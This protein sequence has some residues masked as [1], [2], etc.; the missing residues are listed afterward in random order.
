MSQASTVASEAR[1]MRATSAF[2][3]AKLSMREMRLL[4]RRRGSGLC[5]RLRG[6][7]RPWGH[8]GPREG[9]GGRRPGR[10][11]PKDVG[12]LGGGRTD[13]IPGGV[14]DHREG[15]VRAGPVP[16]RL[17]TPCRTAEVSSPSWRASPSRRPTSPASP[18]LRRAQGILG[19]N[20]PILNHA[21]YIVP[22]SN[23][24]APLREEPPLTS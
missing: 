17:R 20:V 11:D 10:P 13:R 8:R 14:L 21:R 9:D 1:A 2:V 23:S 5:D 3:R 7:R 24:F 4:Q 18:G 19:Y 12:C 16:L 6:S 15:D 22:L